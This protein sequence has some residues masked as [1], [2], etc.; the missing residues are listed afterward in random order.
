MKEWFEGNLPWFVSG[1]LEAGESARMERYIAQHPEAAAQVEAYRRFSEDAKRQ[2]HPT[3]G[4]S[5]GLALAFE[6]IRAVQAGAQDARWR[7]LLAW[8]GR[9]GIS[10]QLAGA[11]AVVLIAVQA[12]FIGVLQREVTTLETQYSE[13]RSAP[14]ASDVGPFIRVSFRPDTKELDV[15]MLLVGIGATYVGGPSQLG[16]Y[17]V[18]VPREYIDRAVEQ[19]NASQLVESAALVA[20]VPPL[21]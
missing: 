6:K 17:Y 8:F 18:H 2:W 21:K 11:A 4:E 14:P 15:R 9:F 3:P 19:L 7:R 20:K 13:Y 12:A 10:P 16:D 5:P 1:T